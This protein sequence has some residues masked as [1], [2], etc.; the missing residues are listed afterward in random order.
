MQFRACVPYV[1]AQTL[2]GPLDGISCGY[3]S[4]GTQTIRAPGWT[5]ATK[6]RHLADDIAIQLVVVGFAQARPRPADPATHPLGRHC[7]G[8]G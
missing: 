4:D 1:G 7:G 5:S 2:F 8:G 3:Y 6:V